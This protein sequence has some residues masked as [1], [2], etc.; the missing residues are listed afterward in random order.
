MTQ[1]IAFCGVGALGS[2][3]ALF[4]RNLEATLVL[5]DFDRVEAK[6]L[7]AQA[8]VKP[9]LGKNKADALKLQLA[10]LHGVRAE[11][12]G[13]RLGPD[14]VETVLA[15]ATLLVDAFDNKASRELLSRYAR[16]HGRPLVHAG[17]AADGSFGMIRWDETFTA[18][19][20]DHAGQATCE[21]GD[22]LPLIA[23]LS[24][25]LARTVADFVK[26]GERRDSLISL[27]S[28]TP[29]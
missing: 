15:G 25:A 23:M 2:H 24:A 13:V 10:N 3:A 21:G 22:H 17:I 8:F 27:A 7:L 26:S 1:R 29:L 6:N 11:S 9:S 19:E 5:I 4:C 18:D 12:F 14:N 28:V 20:E 16:A